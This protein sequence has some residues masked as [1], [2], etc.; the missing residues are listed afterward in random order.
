MQIRTGQPRFE[1]MDNYKTRQDQV[2]GSGSVTTISHRLDRMTTQSIMEDQKLMKESYLRYY[3]KRVV[4]SGP[5]SALSMM[6]TVWQAIWI[7]VDVD[8]NGRMLL[9]EKASGDIAI[10]YFFCAYFLC[11]LLL[12]LFA[13][14]PT[15][16]CL[17]S[18]WFVFDL[19]CVAGSLIEAVLI[20]TVNLIS[21]GAVSNWKGFSAL[22]LVR[23]AK[24]L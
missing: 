1:S 21:R 5:F 4:R 3:L 7:A 15:K 10:E 6:V 22:R 17:Q 16:A 19:V 14:T 2:N 11:E 23:L 12:R 18:R 13:T 8:K 9:F 20:P 24:I